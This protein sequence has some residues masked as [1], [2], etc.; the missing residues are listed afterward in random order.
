MAMAWGKV[1]VLVGERENRFHDLLRVLMFNR[2]DEV[3]KW[4]QKNGGKI[5]SDLIEGI[6]V[7]WEMLSPEVRAV[8]LIVWGGLLGMAWM[9]GVACGLGKGRQEKYNRRHD[10]D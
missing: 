9:Y 6:D 7:A 3:L 1:L 10:D 8:T 5:M 2:F 4:G